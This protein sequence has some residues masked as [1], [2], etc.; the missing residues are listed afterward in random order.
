M[1]PDFV[2]TVTWVGVGV[3][4]GAGLVVSTVVVDSALR[5]VG[6]GSAVKVTRS[7]RLRRTVPFCLHQVRKRCLCLCFHSF[8]C[9]YISY[10]HGLSLCQFGKALGHVVMFVVCGLLPLLYSWLLLIER[11]NIGPLGLEASRYHWYSGPE[12]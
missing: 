2:D 11:C 10:P 5:R 3:G 6:V 9:L 1:R 4:G 12:F 8:W 7:R